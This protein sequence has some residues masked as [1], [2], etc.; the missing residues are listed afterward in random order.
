VNYFLAHEQQRRT[1]M[2]ANSHAVFAMA[3]YRTRLDAL[4]E[5]TS[6]CEAI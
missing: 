1:I 3:D 6:T 4:I 5:Q 2:T